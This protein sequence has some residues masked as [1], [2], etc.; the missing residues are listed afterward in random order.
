MIKTLYGIVD[1]ARDQQ[2]YD[3]VAA[4]PDHVCLFAGELKPPLERT[5]PYLVNLS[6]SLEFVGIWR[7]E[8]GQSWGVTCVSGSGM[9]ELRKHFRQFLQAVL[10]SG[11][12]V[13]F[14]F[15]DPRVFRLYFPTCD[16]A[17]LRTWF[18]CVEE[19]R[20]EAAD[21]EGILVFRL[22]TDGG[23]DPTVLSPAARHASW[24]PPLPAPAVLEE[25]TVRLRRTP[26][27]VSL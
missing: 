20:V 17:Q 3:L 19:F 26:G 8:W 25:A 5:A 7:R 24:L 14:R 21:E 9:A 6:T 12:I 13:L 18:A 23:L 16:A 22:G 15:Y 2:L 11:Q 4:T 10:P 1:T 27:E